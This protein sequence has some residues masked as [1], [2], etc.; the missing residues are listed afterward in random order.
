[1]P[2][3][4]VQQAITTVGAIRCEQQAF[5]ATRIENGTPIFGLD[6]TDQ[7][8]HKRSTAIASP[9]A[10]PKAAT[11]AKKPS[12]ALMPSATSTACSAASVSPAKKIPA[13]E[14]E[15]YASTDRTHEQK[16]IGRVTSACWSPRLESPLAL[17]YVNRGHHELGSRLESNL[18]PAEVVKLPIEINSV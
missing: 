14:L 3:Q 18:G 8:S 13:L 11:L 1:M 10:S 12:P 2:A 17:A 15:L 16:S 5:E 7:N 9:S 4:E 6:I